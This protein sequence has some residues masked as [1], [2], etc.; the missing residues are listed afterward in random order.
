M[1]TEN[2]PENATTVPDDTHEVKKAENQT[3]INTQNQATPMQDSVTMEQK[4]SAIKEKSEI[5]FNIQAS[6]KEKKMARTRKRIQTTPETSKE[7]TRKTEK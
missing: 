1:T 4:L 5:T 2:K 3:K 7:N 6:S